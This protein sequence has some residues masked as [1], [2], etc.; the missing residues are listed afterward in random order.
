MTCAVTYSPTCAPS[1]ASPP[2]RTMRDA[3]TPIA[4][5]IDAVSQSRIRLASLPLVLSATS[6]TLVKARAAHLVEVDL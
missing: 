3:S 5:Y 4:P 6:S 2:P 1:M